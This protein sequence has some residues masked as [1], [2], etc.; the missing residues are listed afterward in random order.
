SA[1]QQLANQD[2]PNSAVGVLFSVPLTSRA[3]RAN[4]KTSKEHKKQAELL[5][6]QKE[7]FILREVADA[8][9]VA[10]FSYQRADAAREAVQFA[11]EALRAE[12]SRRQSGAGS[13][14]LVLEAQ[15]DLAAARSTEA[16]VRRDYNKAISQL[17]FAEGS[18]LDRIQLDVRFR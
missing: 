13:I 15:S 16:A 5:L 14:F 17:Y 2:A 9:D 6:K 3:E 8:I 18:L 1:F 7:E 10:R 11:E 4:Y 12:E